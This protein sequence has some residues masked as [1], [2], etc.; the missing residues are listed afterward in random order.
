MPETYHEDIL[1]QLDAALSNKALMKT[2]GIEPRYENDST[3]Y[4]AWL[5]NSPAFLR[6]HEGLF[7][8]KPTGKAD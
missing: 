1:A 2:M 6:A 5:E 4:D 8:L 3:D 7:V